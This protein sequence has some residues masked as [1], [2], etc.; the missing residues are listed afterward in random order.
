[1]SADRPMRGL[2]RAR[3]RPRLDEDEAGHSPRLTVRLPSR[4]Y[5]QLA[6]RATEEGRSVS[7]AVRSA[8]TTWAASPTLAERAEIRRLVRL[9]DVDREAVFLASNANVR[10]LLERDPS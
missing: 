1:M 3:G 5:R 10:R 8:V 7:D 4:T 9:G 2:S 6:R